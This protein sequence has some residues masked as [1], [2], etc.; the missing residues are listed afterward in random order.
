LTTAARAD[1]EISRLTDAHASWGD[2]GKV[3]PDVML[4]AGP[5]IIDLSGLLNVDQVIALA[6]IELETVRADASVAVIAK[7]S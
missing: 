4:L 2:A 7:L 1:E 5:K 6:K 3:I